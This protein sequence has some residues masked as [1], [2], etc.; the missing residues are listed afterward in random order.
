MMDDVHNW[1]VCQMNMIDVRFSYRFVE[2]H[3]VVRRRCFVAGCI[4]AVLGVSVSYMIWAAYLRS[5]H[6][7]FDQTCISCCMDASN[8]LVDMFI[9]LLSIS[10]PTLL[11]LHQPC[12]VRD[13]FY[14]VSNICSYQRYRWLYHIGFSMNIG[15]MFRYVFVR[16]VCVSAMYS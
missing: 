1:G 16:C 15:V 14:R 11:Y 4:D 2:S 5:L 8:R 12:L 9:R 7:R 6:H 10:I 3:P 13:I